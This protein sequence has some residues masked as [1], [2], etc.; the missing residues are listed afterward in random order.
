MQ[1]HT[2]ERP[3][4]HRL[5]TEEIKAK[6]ND[7]IV[8][9]SDDSNLSLKMPEKQIMTMDKNRMEEGDDSDSEIIKNGVDKNLHLKRKLSSLM[10]LNRADSHQQHMDEFFTKFLEKQDV[11]EICFKDVKDDETILQIIQFLYDN[12]FIPTQ[13]NEELFKLLIRYEKNEYFW[14]CFRFKNELF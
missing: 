4:A 7:D 13:A 6:I 8:N 14:S 1:F 10:F 12:L 3:H 11:I 2:K 9:N 5:D